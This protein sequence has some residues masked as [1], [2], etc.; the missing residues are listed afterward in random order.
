MILVAYLS[1]WDLRDSRRVLR[2]H[3]L[4]HRGSVVFF[5]KT[6]FGRGL[7]PFRAPEPLHT[8]NPS[9]FVPQNGFPV[10]KGLNSQIEEPQKKKLC[11]SM[12]ARVAPRRVC[13]YR[14]V[15]IFQRHICFRTRVAHTHVGRVARRCVFEVM[16]RVK[17]WAVNSSRRAPGARKRFSASLRA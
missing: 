4:F 12:V 2:P 14:L 17:T 9:H 3:G 13:N 10:A 15:L 8:L 11:T 16:L 5:S 7:N 6:G 1:S